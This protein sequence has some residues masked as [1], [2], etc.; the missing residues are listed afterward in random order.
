[1]KVLRIHLRR[2]DEFVA[3]VPRCASAHRSR[4]YSWPS[5][6]DERNTTDRHAALVPAVAGVRT[7]LLGEVLAVGHHFPILG[8]HDAKKNHPE[9]QSK[10][11]PVVSVI[12]RDK[13]GVRVLVDQQPV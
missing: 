12:Q 10:V 7:F 8:Q 9:A 6:V 1:M 11:Q 2:V 13:V 4:S 5:D 3:L